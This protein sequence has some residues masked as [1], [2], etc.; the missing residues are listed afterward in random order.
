MQ[1]PKTVSVTQLVR[2]SA[3]GLGFVLGVVIV[4]TPS[5]IRGARYGRCGRR[6][7]SL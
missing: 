5:T 1:R 7:P 6:S 4:L 2:G 3:A